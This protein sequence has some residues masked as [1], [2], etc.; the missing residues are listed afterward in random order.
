MKNIIFIFLFNVIVAVGNAQAPIA[1]ERYYDFGA[2]EEGYS[3]QQTFDGGYIVAGERRTGVG[4]SNV[5]LQRLDSLGNMEWMQLHGGAFQSKAY[6]V[7]QTTDSGFVL[8]GSV[9]DANYDQFVYLLKT[10]SNGDTIWNKILSDPSYFLGYGRDV[11]QTDDGG[12]LIVADGLFYST[13]TST[14]IYAIKTDSNGDTIWTRKYELYEG[15]YAHEVQQTQDG[16]YIIAGS[17]TLTIF[18]VALGVALIKTDSNGDTSWIRLHADPISNNIRAYGV[19]ETSDGGYFVSGTK[20]IA[21]P[22]TLYVYVEKLD[23]NGDTVWTKTIAGPNSQGFAG[24]FETSDGGFVVGG[25]GTTFSNGGSDALIL[26]LDSG[27][28]VQWQNNFGGINSDQINDIQ[29]TS[30]NGFVMVGL[31]AS[32]GMYDGSIYIIKTDSAGYAPVGI[33]DR[34]WPAPMVAYPNPANESV[35]LSFSENIYNGTIVL[36][37]QLG[38]QVLTEKFSGNTHILLRQTLVAGAYTCVVVSNDGSSLGNKLII[39]Q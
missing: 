32:F 10:D 37:N 21:T 19:V 4:F 5:L 24:G 18:P 38:Q 16:G 20:A 27:G 35:T 7:K 13:D 25:F 26:K 34:E 22:Y 15:A 3:V 6:S 29:L 31:A 17:V 2:T 8:T 14:I 23:A 33:D 11:I 36:Y 30:D 28:A 12:F 39:F 1:F 9:S